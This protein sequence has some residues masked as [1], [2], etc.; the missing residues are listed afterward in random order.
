MKLFK[1]A[2]SGKLKNK[3]F[4]SDNA[5]ISF[6]EE[7]DKPTV[8]NFKALASVSYQASILTADDFYWDEKKNFVYGD[9]NEFLYRDYIP[10][11][12]VELLDAVNEERFLSEEID[13]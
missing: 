13:E 10:P 3:Y 11:E 1:D 8:K 9:G 5:L 2:F 6:V 4:C 12:V 7:N